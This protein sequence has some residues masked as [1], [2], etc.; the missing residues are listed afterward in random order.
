MADAVKN[1]EKPRVLRHGEVCRQHL[2]DTDGRV[3]IPAHEQ[4]RFTIG[5][6]G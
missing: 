6:Q 2:I 3:V 1:V 4:Y 5:C